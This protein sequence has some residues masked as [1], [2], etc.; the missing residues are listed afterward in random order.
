MTW[1]LFF[2][3]LTWWIILLDCV[4]LCVCVCVC[5]CVLSHVQLFVNS[6]TAACQTPLSM[7]FS[8]QENWSGLPFL[9]PGGLLHPRIQPMSLASPAL[10]E[11]FTNCTTWEYQMLN[12]YSWIKRAWYASLMHRWIWF[13]NISHKCFYLCFQK[14]LTY[15]W[16]YI[17]NDYI[18]ININNVTLLY[19]GSPWGGHE[20]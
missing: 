12:L 6:C 9:T 8:R 19:A 16:G 3:L 7:E 15:N 20:L 13:A 11:F 5:V 4:W 10:V 14:R 18:I 17:F 1:F 2:I